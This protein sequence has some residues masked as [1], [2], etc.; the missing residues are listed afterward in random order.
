VKEI[1]QVMIGGP[2]LVKRAMGKTVDKETLGGVAV[3]AK[4]GV[5]DNV[6][7]SEDEAFA[8][9]RQFLS[10]LPQHVWEPAPRRAC[11]D[12]VDRADDALR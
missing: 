11:T 10:Y 4:S 7:E 8:Q 5:V 6:A 1:A 9:I 2:A 3:H 12:P